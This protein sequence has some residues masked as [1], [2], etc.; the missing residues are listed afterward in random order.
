MD[1][2]SSM[3]TAAL[4]VTISWISLFASLMDSLHPATATFASYTPPRSLSFVKYCEKIV[5]LYTVTK[6]L[7]GYDSAI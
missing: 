3:S 1:I 2:H 5:Q 6:L 7:L 4:G